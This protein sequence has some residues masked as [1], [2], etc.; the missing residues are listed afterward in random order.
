MFPLHPRQFIV[1][2]TPI[3]V[4]PAQAGIQCR[5]FTE[6]QSLNHPSR[7]RQ[8][9]INIPKNVIHRFNPH[10]QTNQIGWHTGSDL[11]FFR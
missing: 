11:L 5:C 2:P 8:R 1:R 9:L 7:L 4:I 3:P 10:C 6:E